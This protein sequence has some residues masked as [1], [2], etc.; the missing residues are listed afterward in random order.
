MSTITNENGF[1]K[2]K[3]SSKLS[4]K[5]RKPKI[6]DI[7]PAPVPRSSHRIRTSSI[8]SDDKLKVNKR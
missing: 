5:N 4:L 6:S 1:S 3:R 8:D 2:V 7:S